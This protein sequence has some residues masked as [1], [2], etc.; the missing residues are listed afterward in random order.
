MVSGVE[1]CVTSGFRRRGLIDF[2]P[3]LWEDA[4]EGPG[5]TATVG[6]GAWPFPTQVVVRLARRPRGIPPWSHV[7]NERTATS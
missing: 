4:K 1:R 6:W 2:C 3:T 5:R 7:R